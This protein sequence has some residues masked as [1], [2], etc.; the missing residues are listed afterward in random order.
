MQTFHTPTL[1]WHI[2]DNGRHHIKLQRGQEVV[3][4]DGSKAEK[5]ASFAAAKRKYP[6]ISEQEPAIHT[7][8]GG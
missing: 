6:L 8:N 2:V 4:P 3:Y 7:A 5:F 1:K